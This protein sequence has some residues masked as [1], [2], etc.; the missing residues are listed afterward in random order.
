[1]RRVNI[2][3]YARHA[4]SQSSLPVILQGLYHLGGCLLVGMKC[5]HLIDVG[6]RL[7]KVQFLSNQFLLTLVADDRKSD[8]AA[9]RALRRIKRVKEAAQ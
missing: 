4:I 8:R 9:D 2:K 7:D 6:D 3:D 5:P 1:V